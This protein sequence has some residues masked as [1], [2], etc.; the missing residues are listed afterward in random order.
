MK[1][2]IHPQFL[3]FSSFINQLPYLFEREGEVLHN[4]R[5][6]VKRFKVGEVMLVV[7]RYKDP[8]FFQR[9]AYSFFKPSKA[10]RAFNYAE[11]YRAAGFD[12]PAEVAYIEIGKGSLFHTSYFVCLNSEKQSIANRLKDMPEARCKLV[13]A[14]AELLVRMHQKGIAHG[15]LNI[16]N[17]LFEES[18]QGEFQFTFIDINRTRFGKLSAS[19][20]MKN[21]ARTTHRLDLYGYLVSKYAQIR[22]WNPTKSLLQAVWYLFL[23][24]RKETFKALLK[25]KKGRS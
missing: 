17:I 8:N 11:K 5:N 21:M 15:D 7:K 13:D 4:G 19:A 9:I 22:G 6:V 20:C 25:E 23:L 1:A 10:A 24:E 3:R 16:S 18:E 12:T 14:F 2:V